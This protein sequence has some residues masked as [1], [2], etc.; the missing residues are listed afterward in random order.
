MGASR[1]DSQADDNS[2]PSGCPWGKGT[3]CSGLDH[4]VIPIPAASSDTGEVTAT[5]LDGHRSRPALVFARGQAQDS[6]CSGWAVHP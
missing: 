2:L 6:C 5:F 3:S 1:L 4:G